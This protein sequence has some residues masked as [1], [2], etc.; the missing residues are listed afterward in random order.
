MSLERA[1]QKASQIQGPATLDEFLRAIA[2]SQKNNH[3]LQRTHEPTDPLPDIYTTPPLLNYKKPSYFYIQQS[4]GE[5]IAAASCL[6][7]A[8]HKKMEISAICVHP[9]H[10]DQGYGGALLWT[11][12]QHACTNKLSLHIPIFTEK[13]K[14][15]LAPLV[16][17]LHRHV[18]DLKIR[19]GDST[20]TIRGHK[21][22]RLDFKNDSIDFSPG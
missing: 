15:Y 5:I 11:V 19:F 20:N 6:L 14:N 21:P 3:L 17:Q 1:F 22:Y 9:L 12:M 7:V 10:Q 8:R 18:P 16:P 13:G 2:Q 4:D